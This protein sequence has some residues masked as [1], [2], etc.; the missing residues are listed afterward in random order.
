MT[1]REHDYRNVDIKGKRFG[2]LVAKTKVEGYITR[3]IFQCDCGNETI[4][5][6]YQAINGKIKSCG[7]L[8]K[9][10]HENLGKRNYKHGDS[11]KRIRNIYN[12]MISRCTKPN[13]KAYKNYG[14]RGIKVCDEWFN[15]YEAFKEWAYSTGFNPNLKGMKEQS[16]DRIDNNGDYSPSNCQWAS[17]KEQARNRRTIKY[18]PYNGKQYCMIEFSETFNIPYSYVRYKISIG[19]SYEDI[20]RGW[21]ERINIP[22]GYIDIETCA[23]IKGVAKGSVWRWYKKGKIKGIMC[24]R[25]LYVKI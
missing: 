22:K 19:K 2:K 7:C 5:C 12:D 13:N 11:L 10:V 9:E 15:S 4:L 25:K 17:V 3:W 1:T 20:I 18:Y 6:A 8:T 21:N 16:L 24:G 14:G 23:K